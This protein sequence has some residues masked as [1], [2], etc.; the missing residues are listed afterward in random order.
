MH[1][2]LTTAKENLMAD[3][4]CDKCHKQKPASELRKCDKCGTVICDYCR[5]GA[6]DCNPRGKA[7]CSGHLK[8]LG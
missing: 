6:S 2:S 7:F 1:A 8:K 5:F 4:T 3:A